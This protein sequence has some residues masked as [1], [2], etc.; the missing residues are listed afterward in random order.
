[1]QPTEASIIHINVTD[2]AAAVEVAKNP[3][4]ADTPPFVIALEGSARTVVLTP[5]SAERGR[6]GG[7]DPVC[8]PPFCNAADSLPAGAPPLGQSKHGGESR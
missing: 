7:F 3:S 5:P 2:F 8:P 1:M 6:K 4:L